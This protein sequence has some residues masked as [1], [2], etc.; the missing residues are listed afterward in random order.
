MNIVPIK[1][2]FSEK[3]DRMATNTYTPM[4]YAHGQELSYD[5]LIAIRLTNSSI[6]PLA[7]ILTRSSTIYSYVYLLTLF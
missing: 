4:Q 3:I 2:T 6:K 7:T 1:S 5:C